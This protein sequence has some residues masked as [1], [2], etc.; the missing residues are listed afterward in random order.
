MTKLD[1]AIALARRGFRVFPCVEGTKRPLI[2]AWPDKATTDEAQLRA[3]WEPLPESN[4]AIAAGRGLL[5]VDIDVKPG[6]D[7]RAWLKA[8]AGEGRFLPPTM[9][10]RTPSGGTHYYF[11][12]HPDQVFRNSVG[13]LAPG[14]DVRAE[15]GYVLGP[16]AVVD[17]REYAEIE[18]S[19]FG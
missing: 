11:R 13:K 15:G 1:H 19:I 18:D 10:V 3:W 2:T 12:H 9:T 5:I 17:G 16:G 7:G 14:V 8:I 6:K 4:P